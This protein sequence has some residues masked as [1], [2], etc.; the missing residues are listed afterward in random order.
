[1]ATTVPASTSRIGADSENPVSASTRP[2]AANPPRKARAA[3][4]SSGSEIPNAAAAVSARWAPAFTAKVS[5]EANGFRA[6]PVS[7]CVD[8]GR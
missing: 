1:M 4:L 6:L 5:G 7:E 8:P 3:E 2:A